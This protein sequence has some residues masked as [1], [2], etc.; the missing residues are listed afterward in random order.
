[1]LA[2]LEVP[3][4]EVAK[5]KG[6]RALVERQHRLD[7]VEEQ[8]QALLERRHVIGQRRVLF[9]LQRKRFPVVVH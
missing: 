1:M 5:P 6:V 2:H 3:V 7:A 9:D 8:L 4:L